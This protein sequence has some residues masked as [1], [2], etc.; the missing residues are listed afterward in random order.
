MQATASGTTHVVATATPSIGGT[1]R[2]SVGASGVRHGCKLSTCSHCS[3]GGG[4]RHSSRSSVPTI[5]RM[6][7]SHPG[8]HRSSSNCSQTS[9]SET[10]S[11][12]RVSQRQQRLP[13]SVGRPMSTTEL[14]E[15][16]SNY[17]E[18]PYDRQTPVLCGLFSS[19]TW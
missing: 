7:L 4:G 15:S 17:Q 11:P 8:C 2:S 14:L 12:C 9:Q 1:D 10:P 3:L 6:Q 13:A 19:T 16:A 5:F 18:L